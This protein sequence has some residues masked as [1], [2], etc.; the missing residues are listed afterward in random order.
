MH[1]H[2]TEGRHRWSLLLLCMAFVP[3]FQLLL[4]VG[5]SSLLRQRTVNL[6]PRSGPAKTAVPD[7]TGAAPVLKAQ[8]AA[9]AGLGRSPSERVERWYAETAPG[10]AG[11]DRR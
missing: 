2:L 3:T 7:C 8:A 5:D 1:P 10:P 6:T 11:T 9:G 4:A